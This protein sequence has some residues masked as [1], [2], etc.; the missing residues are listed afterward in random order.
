MTPEKRAKTQEAFSRDDLDVVCATIA[1]GMGIDKSNVRFVLHRD[2][3]RSI[4]GYYQEIGRAGR[5][6]APADCVLFY[7]WADV[8]SLDRLLENSGV[9]DAEVAEQ[10]RRAVRRMMDLADGSSCLWRRLAAHFAELIPACETSC[11]SCLK[12]DIVGEAREIGRKAWQPPQKK[13]RKRRAAID[14]E[15][16]ESDE[17]P[18]PEPTEAMPD[19][20]LFERLRALRRKLADEKKV[21]A[22]VVFSDKA[23]LDM[24]ARR[25]Q[26]RADFLEVHGVGQRKREEYGDVFLAEIRANG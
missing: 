12:R 1:F 15:S 22:F 20:G 4:E 6:G 8:L 25:P 2:M 17:R 14:P 24:A 23:L 10:Q 7:S 19:P 26:S 18:S 21:P 3:P 5:D 13:E 9:Q 11:G 16:Y